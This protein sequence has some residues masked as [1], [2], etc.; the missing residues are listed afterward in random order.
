MGVDLNVR[1]SKTLVLIVSKKKIDHLKNAKQKHWP[2]LSRPPCTLQ[3]MCTWRDLHCPELVQLQKK[4]WLPP[5]SHLNWIPVVITGQLVIIITF[6]IHLSVLKQS[7][8]IKE[9]FQWYMYYSDS[10]KRL[11]KALKFAWPKRTISAHSPRFTSLFEM[12]CTSR[13]GSVAHW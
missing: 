6:L 1:I 12:L 7:T 13:S 3:E 5:P 4:R 11:P 8:I 9:E 2:S 10:V